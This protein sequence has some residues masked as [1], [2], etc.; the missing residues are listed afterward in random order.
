MSFAE[1][2][3]SKKVMTLAECLKVIHAA[4]RD[5]P[6]FRDVFSSFNNEAELVLSSDW[7]SLQDISGIVFAGLLSCSAKMPPKAALDVEFQRMLSLVHA[8]L[9]GKYFFIRESF[10]LNSVQR[11]K[12]NEEVEVKIDSGKALF[13]YTTYAD[14]IE[15]IKRI[16][17]VVIA[18]VE[19]PIRFEQRG[20]DYYLVPLHSGL[21][22]TTD[23][24]TSVDGANARMF[25]CEMP[26]KNIGDLL[27]K[28]ATIIEMLGDGSPVK[29][30]WYYSPS[31]D[32]EDR[33]P[34]RKELEFFATNDF[35]FSEVDICT[36]YS[37]NDLEV[38]GALEKLGVKD[39]WFKTS[40]AL[41][42]FP[43]SGPCELFVNTTPKGHQ[44]FVTLSDNK[45]IGKVQDVLHTEFSPSNMWD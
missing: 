33:S 32:P 43:G 20:K 2:L 17:N 26:C 39:T 37:I 18:A 3:A 35:P 31:G 23:Y 27:P 13:S 34:W 14:D 5:F 28:V 11:G 29:G 38:L 12:R 19:V 8:V 10:R 42:E 40:V 44:L 16:F 4:K 45:L 30:S 25:T 21:E 15:E 1:T 24:A 6:G 7:Q 36:C 22:F 9:P 41:F